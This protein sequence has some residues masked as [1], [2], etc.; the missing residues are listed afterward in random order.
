[1]LDLIL[2]TARQDVRIRAVILNGS[3]ANPN[4]TPDRFQD[5]DIVYV[6]TDLTPFVEDP[7]WIYPQEELC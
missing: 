5:F 7:A 1:M 4:V 3:R 2:G 6:V